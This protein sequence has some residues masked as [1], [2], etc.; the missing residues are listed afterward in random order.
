V[1]P[2]RLAD[3]AAEAVRSLNHATIRGAG[4]EFPADAYDVLGSLALLA[5]RLPQALGQVQDFLD[6]AT[7]AGRVAVVDG[8]HA[9]DPVAA[10]TVCA[11]HL[12]HATVAAERLH[13]ALDA[14]RAAL[15]WAAA[16]DPA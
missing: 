13:A 10:V 16:T 9:G 6:D 4:L 15:V 5:A 7:E 3:Q 11:H 2:A 14:A 12:D 1:T 8:E